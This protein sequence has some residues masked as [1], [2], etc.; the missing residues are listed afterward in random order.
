VVKKSC[1]AADPFNHKERKVAPNAPS[2]I[3]YL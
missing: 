3:H 2:P 1:R